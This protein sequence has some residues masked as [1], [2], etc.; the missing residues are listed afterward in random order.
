[1]L[2]MQFFTSVLV[3][4]SSLLLALYSTS[5]M[6]VFRVMAD[7]PTHP[8]VSNQRGK[9]HIVRIFNLTEILMH[10]II[11]IMKSSICLTSANIKNSM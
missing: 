11:I 5:M 1:M 10:I 2:M 4:T 7:T 9:Q 8:P 3:R 6:R